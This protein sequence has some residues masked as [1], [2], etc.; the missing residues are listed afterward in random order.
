MAHSNLARIRESNPVIPKWFPV[1]TVPW[2]KRYASIALPFCILKKP[3][4]I[5]SDASLAHEWLHVR[6]WWSYYIIGF[7]IAYF[8][9]Q[10]CRAL[11]KA[12]CYAV[13]VA[14]GASIDECAHF[15][16]NYY[17]IKNFHEE[18]ALVW[19]RYFI[20]HPENILPK[21]NE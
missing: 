20:Q 3:G 12:Q 14:Y 9:S 21:V 15:M 7:I 18:E 10:K 8:T 1:I 19:I 5:L 6:Q 11:L 4:T 13:S 2:M 16:A 17:G